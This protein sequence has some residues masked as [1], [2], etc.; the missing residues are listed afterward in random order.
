MR[1]KSL[2]VRALFL[3]FV[4]AALASIVAWPRLNE[5]ETGRTPEYPDLQAREYGASLSKVFSAAK[6]AVINLPRWTLVGAGRGP[7][8][9]EIKATARAS[10]LPLKYAVTVRLSRRGG[11]TI[12][13]VRSRSE[14]GPWDFGQNARNIRQF[15]QALDE[16]LFIL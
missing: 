2:L 5:V 16:E 11:R 7:A 8:S 12:V 15:L 3:A 9:S 6:G 14:F 1:I 4:G 13:S 10:I